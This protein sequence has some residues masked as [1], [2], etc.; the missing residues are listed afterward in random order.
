MNEL[1][2]DQILEVRGYVLKNYPKLFKESH[3]LTIKSIGNVIGI[4]KHIDESPLILSRQI[5]S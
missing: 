1:T 3:V 2:K 4:S 5:L